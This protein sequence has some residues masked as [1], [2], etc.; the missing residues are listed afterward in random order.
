[1]KPKY[2]SLKRELLRETLIQGVTASMQNPVMMGSNSGGAR[3]DGKDPEK[4]VLIGTNGID[5]DYV[6]TM[7]MELVSGRA[8]SKDF[9]ADIS[10]G[11]NG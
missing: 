4:N 7:K 10:H 9:T 11:H 5:Y 6:E 8:F 1:M 3:W 2:Y